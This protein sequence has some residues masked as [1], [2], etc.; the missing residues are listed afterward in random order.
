MNVAFLRSY[1]LIDGS[2]TY[3]MRLA[4]KLVEQGHTVHFISTCDLPAAMQSQLDAIAPVVFTKDLPALP[5]SHPVFAA[6][7]IH[8]GVD[9]DYIQYA[10]DLKRRFF[11]KAAVVF[12]AWAS[13][14]FIHRSVIGFSPDGAFYRYFLNRLPAQNIAFMGPTIR[15]K[16]VAFLGN[17]HLKRSPVIPNSLELPQQYAERQRADRKKLVSIGRLAPS[18]EYVFVTVD[19]LK[20]LRMEGMELEFHLYGDGPFVPM[21]QQR[22]VEEGLQEFVTLHGEIPYAQVPSALADAGYFIGMG[23]AII[24]AAAAGVP[25]I[26]AIE[27]S[28]EPGMYGWFHQLQDGEIGEY[29]KGKPQVPLTD[30]LREAVKWDDADYKA[31]C[32]ASFERSRHFALDHVIQDYLAFLQGADKDFVLHLPYWKRWMLKAFRQPFKLLALPPSKT[33]AR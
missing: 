6:E 20:Q 11:P 4:G 25:A 18:K 29:R 23:A 32:S 33:I 2:L 16:H 3:K 28:T 17:E 9:G 7:A 13:N 31:A 22:I 5:A 1:P 14:A 30:L 24:E 12:G 21:L 10:Y 15:D 19:A 27:Y 8:A 26:Q